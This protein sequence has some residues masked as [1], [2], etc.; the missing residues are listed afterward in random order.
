MKKDS[1]HPL[2]RDVEC[3]TGDVNPAPKLYFVA[4]LFRLLSL[5]VL[6]LMIVQV[7]LAVTSTV[8]VSYGVLFGEA[9]RLFVGAGVLWA[10]GDLSDLFVK[11]H[12]DI[13]AIRISLARLA[14][15]AAETNAPR[16]DEH[17]N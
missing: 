2:F 4:I 3:R 9:V 11:T 10:A 6:L 5:A 8:S 16:R 7:A 15:R 1:C 13:L 17:Q 12:V 14:P